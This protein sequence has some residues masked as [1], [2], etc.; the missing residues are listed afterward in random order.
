MERADLEQWKAREVARLLRLVE[1]ERRYYQEIAAS[2]PVGL[3]VVSPD[4]TIVSANRAIRKIFGLAKSPLR[5]P[6]HTLF[7][8]GL[9]D[10]VMEVLRV[11]QPQTNILV[12]APQPLRVGILAITSWDDESSQEIMICVE[13][14]T[15]AEASGVLVPGTAT[16]VA[17]ESPERRL[18]EDQL[19]QSER[20]QAMTKLAARLAHDLNNML[21]I[22]TGH[23]EELMNNL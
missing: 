11:G 1:T 18:L 13:D 5:S 21:M 7:P 9:I 22:V 19:V 15:G 17:P 12:L 14:L 10:R 6:L 20:M 4:L 3:L 2:I 8:A 16:A 23:A